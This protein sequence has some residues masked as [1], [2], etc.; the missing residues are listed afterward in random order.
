MARCVLCDRDR[1]DDATYARLYAAWGAI[2][3]RQLRARGGSVAAEVSALVGEAVDAAQCARHFAR[4]ERTQ[5]PPP[6]SLTEERI[7]DAQEA[8]SPRQLEVIRLVGRLGAT[9][10]AQV[11]AA[12]YEGHLA[13]RNAARAA[14]Y[15]ELRPLM[16]GH[17]LYRA[18]YRRARG[19][20]EVRDPAIDGA[21]LL[22]PGRAALGLLADSGLGR[23]R[24]VSAPEQVNPEVIRRRVKAG[25]VFVDLAQT[26]RAAPPPT[27]EAV[28]I[29]MGSWCGTP[30][31][32]ARMHHLA[33]RRDV[34]VRLDG[35][36][37]VSLFAPSRGI[38]LA[39]PVAWVYDDGADEPAALAERLAAL[40][41]LRFGTGLSDRIAGCVQPPLVLYVARDGERLDVVHAELRA[42]EA[43]RSEAEWV[44]V[45][46]IDAPTMRGRAWDAPTWSWL[47]ARGAAGERV[48]LAPVCF[49]R[50]QSARA[51]LRHDAVLRPRRG[52]D[53]RTQEA[54]PPALPP[55]GEIVAPS[56]VGALR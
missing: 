20:V 47:G 26:L 49:R 7:R 1:V 39:T 23:V 11:C 29:A 3:N 4:H 27:T 12:L 18:S 14:C 34:R 42:R 31:L 16:F 41:V 17:F 28:R 13:T 32:P 6:R 52:D 45:L 53:A 55:A 33:Y 43:R 15:R 24:A 35:I 54:R 30:C 8:L 38:D 50:A 19:R 25:Q 56:P 9:S 21:A 48:A 37:L 5:P 51:P 2:G 44:E 10:A 36:C 40:G 22:F 46:A